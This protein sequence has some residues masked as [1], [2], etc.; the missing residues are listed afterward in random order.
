VPCQ[1]DPTAA[2]D[3]LIN[4]FCTSGSQCSGDQVCGS[5][6]ICDLGSM[7]C[8]ALCSNNSLSTNPALQECSGGAGNWVAFDGPNANICGLNGKGIAAATFPRTF[9]AACPKGTHEVWSKFVWDV[10]TPQGTQVKF[11]FRASNSLAD[12]DTAPATLIATTGYD[13]PGSTNP[14]ADPSSCAGSCYKDLST[15]L[16][17]NNTTYIKMEAVLTRNETDG[18]TPSLNAWNVTFNCLPSE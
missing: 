6:N 1:H 9:Q 5:G 17:P 11:L 13:P 4:P 15:L 8:G 16:N 10:S 18:T 14:A 12:I 7:R 2:T 3:F